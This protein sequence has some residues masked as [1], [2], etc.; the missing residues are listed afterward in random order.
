MGKHGQNSTIK[1][2][3]HSVT[4]H[5]VR[6]VQALITIDHNGKTKPYFQFGLR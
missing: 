1:D 4:E 6:R 3:E 2:T 5:I